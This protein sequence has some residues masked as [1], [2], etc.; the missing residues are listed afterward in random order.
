MTIGLINGG[1]AWLNAFPSM[2]GVSR[3]MSPATIVTGAPKPNMKHKHIVFGSHA[4][5]FIGTTNK[6][7]SRSVPAIA[8]NASNNHG[9]HYFM[10]LYSGKRIHSYEWKEVPIDD[11]V[12]L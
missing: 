12:I 6:M 2:D 4:M 11:D 1:V 8:L 5:V 9:G 10:S 7:D 3:T